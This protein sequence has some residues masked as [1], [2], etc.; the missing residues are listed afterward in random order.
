MDPSDTHSRHSEFVRFLANGMCA[1]A[2]HYAVLD[3][4]MRILQFPSA[5]AANLVAAGF[6]IV[7]SFMGSRYFVFRAAAGSLRAQ[8]T[9]FALLYAV[10]AMLHGTVL[11]LWTDVGGRDYRLGFIL[12]TSMQ[13]LLSYCGN[14]FLVFRK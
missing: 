3:V 11:Y 8:G 2:V 9:R 4:N 5:G 7:A 10:T 12:A 1:T 14:R 13:V 6:G